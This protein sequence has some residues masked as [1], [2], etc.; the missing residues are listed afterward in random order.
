MSL[1]RTEPAHVRG[2]RTGQPLQ[3]TFCVPLPWCTSQ[4]AISTRS[5]PCCACATREPMAMLLNRQKPIPRAA[6]A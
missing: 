5:T 6:D 4:S 2:G 3:N 1:P